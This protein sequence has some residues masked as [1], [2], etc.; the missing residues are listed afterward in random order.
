MCLRVALLVSAPLLVI[1]LG[2][3][4]T[5][6]APDE[7]GPE[8]A[9]LVLDFPVAKQVVHEFEDG[10]KELVAD[11]TITN[12]SRVIKTVPTVLMLIR[13]PHELPLWREEIAPPVRSIRPGGVVKIHRYIGVLPMSGRVLEIGW[14]PYVANP[15]NDA[16]G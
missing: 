4:A 7:F 13:G 16:D 9:G 2:S 10:S 1:G 11:G 5:A 8:I 3:A 12:T 15:K 6:A 14:A